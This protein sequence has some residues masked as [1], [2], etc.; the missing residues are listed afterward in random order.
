MLLLI[1][2]IF[3]FIIKDQRWR[4]V[5]PLFTQGTTFT[6]FIFITV[7]QLHT[8]R[9]IGITYSSLSVLV[10]GFYHSHVHL[11]G[12]FHAYFLTL[13]SSSPTNISLEWRGEV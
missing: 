1:Y 13:Q 7:A 2:C 4:L 6:G 12:Y 3:L 9:N 10:Y 8:C 5:G 11:F